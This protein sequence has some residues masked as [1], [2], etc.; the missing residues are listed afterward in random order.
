MLF[1]NVSDT[2][3]TPQ[4]VF[5]ISPGPQRYCNKLQIQC[6]ST[7]LSLDV[8]F[9]NA[10]CRSKTSVVASVHTR[11][12]CPPYGETKISGNGNGLQVTTPRSRRKNGKRVSSTM[13]G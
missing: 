10:T 3:A 5:A 2:S 4:R 1:S 12:C 8:P 6:N 11:H 13:F 9:S 7:P